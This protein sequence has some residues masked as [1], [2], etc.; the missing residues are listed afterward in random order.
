MKIVLTAAEIR[1]LALFC[2]FHVD[3]NGVETRDSEELEMEYA[4]EDCPD[5]GILNED[6]KNA[7]H[8]KH[9]V[10]SEDY[11]DEGVMGLGPELIHTAPSVPPASKEPDVEA[12]TGG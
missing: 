8:Y 12:K 5:Q 10:Y 7:L 2:G 11:P 1:D 6:E 9:I 4:I 3:E